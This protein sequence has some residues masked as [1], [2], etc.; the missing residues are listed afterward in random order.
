MGGIQD[1]GVGAITAEDRMW[2]ELGRILHKKCR[3]GL[4]MKEFLHFLEEK[5]GH[6]AKKQYFCTAVP[7]IPL[8]DMML[9]MNPG[10]L[11]PMRGYP[12]RDGM[13]IKRNQRSVMGR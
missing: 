1:D 8:P 3:I 9:V 11:W 10:F 2:D 13:E 12:Q 4:K 7:V 6:F 5:F